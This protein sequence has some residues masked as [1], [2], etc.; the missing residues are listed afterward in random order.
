[1]NNKKKKFH[2]KICARTS[3]IMKVYT[4]NNIIYKGYKIINKI[5]I[6]FL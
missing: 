6:L 1:M 4:D 3:F 5:L 2:K